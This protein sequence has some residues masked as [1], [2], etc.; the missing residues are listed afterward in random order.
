MG[1]AGEHG[2]NYQEVGP[3]GSSL[4]TAIHRV[5][6][7]PYELVRPH[8]ASGGSYRNGLF[9]Q[10]D[11]I[12]FRSRRNVGALVDYQQRRIANGGPQSQ[13]QIGQRPARQVFLPHLNQVDTSGDRLGYPVN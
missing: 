12:G 9:A 6:R 1:A 11:S 10:L 13:S 7:P 4:N 2:A 3:A 5:Y 8:D